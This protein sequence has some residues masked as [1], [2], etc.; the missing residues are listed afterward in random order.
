M[1]DRYI[2]SIRASMAAV[3][4]EFAWSEGRYKRACSVQTAVAI[5]SVAGDQ[6]VRIA[7]EIDAGFSNEIEEGEFV[8][9]LML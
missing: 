9:Y 7:A 8:V 5:G 6:F 1:S 2:L 4:T 3:R